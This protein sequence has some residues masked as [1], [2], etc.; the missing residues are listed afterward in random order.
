MAVPLPGGGGG[1]AAAWTREMQAAKVTRR[2]G[3]WAWVVRHLSDKATQDIL[4]QPPY[5]QDHLASIA[6]LDGY[7]DTPIRTTDLRKMNREWNDL[8]RLVAGGR[9]TMVE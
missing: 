9:R 7:Y 5:F 6:Y 8:R 1:G 2:K 4:S 3:L